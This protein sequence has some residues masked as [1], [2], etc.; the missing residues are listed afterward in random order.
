MSVIGPPPKEEI[1]AS[2]EVMKAA[3]EKRRAAEILARR[4]EYRGLEVPVYVL[5]P[6]WADGYTGTFLN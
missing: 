3:V 4:L 1:H 6:G 5:R 2:Q